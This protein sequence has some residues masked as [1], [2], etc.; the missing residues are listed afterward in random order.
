MQ[1]EKHEVAIVGAGPAGLAAAI[2]L[3]RLGVSDIVV[4]DR[5]EAAGGMPQNCH[6]TGFGLRD[7]HMLHTGPGYAQTYVRRAEK[8]SIDIRKSTTVTGWSGATTLAL[9]SPRGLAEV[10]AKTILLATGCRER[11]RAARLIPGDRPQGIFTTGSL[12]HFLH[13]YH[14]PVGKKAVVVGSELVG[15]SA[16]L[17]LA[18][19]HIPVAAM[20][21]EAPHYELA[22]PYVPAK[23]LLADIWPRTALLTSA[24]VSRIIGKKRVEAVEV[25]SA[26]GKTEIID[27]DT[28]VFSADWIPQNELAR[29]GGLAIDTGTRGPRVDAYLRTSAPGVFAAGNVLRGAEMADAAALE[30]RY[31]A[32]SMQT[33][34]NRG[35]WPSAAVPVEV[36]DPLLWIEPNAVSPQDDAAPL[37]YALLRVKSEIANATL[38]VQQGE[39]T[40]HRQH[41]G[42]LRLG[43]AHRLD[44]TWMPKVDASGPPVRVTAS[45]K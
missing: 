13:A 43:T 44:A 16:M 3:K 12:Q 9:T 24:H 42:R 29:S 45:T 38:L 21:T 23:W 6:H 31:V 25:V 36:A 28:V 27:C 1:R 4:L 2:E 26:S 18:G 7:L 20:T 8:A 17:S 19:A 39:K 34:L 14:Y 35:V 37:G 41:L 10:E 32:R 22:W 33:Y 5:E 30:G 40:L 15:F 11:P